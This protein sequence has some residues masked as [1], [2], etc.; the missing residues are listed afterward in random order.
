M[1]AKDPRADLDAAISKIEAK[2]GIKDMIHPASSSPPV[3][4]LPFRNPHL[5]YATEGGAPW[6]RSISLYGE[7][8]TGKT[9]A[10]YELYAMAQALPYSMDD[11]WRRRIEYHRGHGHAKVV[12]ALEDEIAWVHDQFPDGAECCHYDIE[13]QFDKRR[14][15]KV[16]VDVDRLYLSELNVIEDICGA[17]SS[18]FPLFHIHGL[19]STSNATSM[20]RLKHD[21]GKSLFGVDAR[22]W[23]Y[24]LRDAFTY[25]GPLKNGTGI[26]NMLVMIHQMSTNASTGASQAAVGKYI[27]FISSCSVRFS[28]GAFLWE[29]NGVL[30]SDKTAAYGSAEKADKASMAGV[31]EA[32][33]AEIYA[34]IEKSRTCRPFRAAGM[35]FDYKRLTYR[36]LHE[37]ASSAL[38][39]GIIEKRGS[40][41]K[42]AGEE[43]ALGQ[44]LKA[45]YERLAD[46]GDLRDQIMARLLDFHDEGDEI[47]LSKNYEVDEQARAVNEAVESLQQAAA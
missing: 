4:H 41:F 36:P 44:G 43:E 39:Y 29:K 19:D 1:T 7:E 15:A 6:N 46:D 37:L 35:Q 16:G 17:L 5:T 42:V 3:F 21:P 30:L 23:K 9:L 32:D 12:A 28:R 18:L 10:L 25:F 22:Q 38:Y 14:A 20:L 45:V 8:S 34:K 26:P 24:A 2:L 33:G 27:K 13:G 47:D 11:L 31:A 40:W